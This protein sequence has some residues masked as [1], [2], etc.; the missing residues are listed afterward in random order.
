M[1]EIGQMG[2]PSD[3]VKFLV[4]EGIDSVEY[5]A[6]FSDGLLENVTKNGRRFKKKVSA[7]PLR[8]LKVT[9]QAVRYYIA[10]GQPITVDNIKWSP[11]L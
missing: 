11:V 7:M 9:A 8:R 2:L 4:T 3:T 6:D 1:E 10:V 5:F